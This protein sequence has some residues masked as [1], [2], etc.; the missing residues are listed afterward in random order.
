MNT[1]QNLSPQ[2]IISAAR[3]M[4]L[5]ELENLVDEVLA[6]QATRRAPHIS[7]DESNLLKII[8][9][10]LSET[11]LN[12]MRELQIERDAQR[13][14]AEDYAELARLTDRV[15]ELHAE[16]ISAVAKLAELRGSTLT[17]TIKQIGLNLPDYE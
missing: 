2:E 7:A 6:V 13:L 12:R 3:T 1:Q 9:Q 16:R 5:A 14:S 15:E 10:T 11:E 4:P 17:E 8:N